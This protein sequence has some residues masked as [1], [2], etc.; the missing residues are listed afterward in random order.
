MTNGTLK[1]SKV[2]LISTT[3]IETISRMSIGTGESDV[4]SEDAD[5]FGEFLISGINDAGWIEIMKN[6]EV[7]VGIMNSCWKKQFPSIESG[8]IFIE[9][10]FNLEM[11][12]GDFFI[13][14]GTFKGC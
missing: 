3:D 5:F 9:S 13:H 2:K 7:W 4:F 11:T 12:I 10:R 6:G 1:N 8:R 14:I